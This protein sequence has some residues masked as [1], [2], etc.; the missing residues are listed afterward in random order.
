MQFELNPLNIKIYYFKFNNVQIDLISLNDE[1]S[2]VS[3]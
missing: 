3:S 2:E 1:D